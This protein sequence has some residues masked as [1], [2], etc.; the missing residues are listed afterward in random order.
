MQTYPRYTR[1]LRHLLADTLPP[2]RS[3]RERVLN[4][5]SLLLEKY[6]VQ[7]VDDAIYLPFWDVAFKAEISIQQFSAAILFVYIYSIFI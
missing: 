6:S 1:L 4:P 5:R 7:Y 3:F 2:S